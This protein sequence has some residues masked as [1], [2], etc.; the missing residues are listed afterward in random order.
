VFGGYQVQSAHPQMKLTMGDKQTVIDA[1]ITRYPHVESCVPRHCF[2]GCVTGALHYAKQTSIDAEGWFSNCKG[3][4]DIL[5]GRGFT[6]DVLLRGV[7]NYGKWNPLGKLESR[8]NEAISDICGRNESPATRNAA[9]VPITAA[10]DL[11]QRNAQHVSRSPIRKVQVIENPGMLCYF[12]AAIGM[13]RA[14]ASNGLQSAIDA[15]AGP[16]LSM[17]NGCSKEEMRKWALQHKLHVDQPGR[18]DEAFS[19]LIQ[20]HRPL[21]ASFKALQSVHM[22]CDSCCAVSTKDDPLLIHLT[23]KV[24]SNSKVV[25]FSLQSLFDRKTNDVT[26]ADF[27]C[28]TCGKK[29]GATE[30]TRMTQLPDAVFVLVERSYMDRRDDIKKFRLHLKEIES[31]SLPMV[32]QRA[33]ANYRLVATAAY[34]GRPSLGHYTYYSL[35]GTTWFHVNPGA[36]STPGSSRQVAAK[37][38][39]FAQSNTMAV[40]YLKESSRLQ[41]SAMGGVGRRTRSLSLPSSVRHPQGMKR[42]SLAVSASTRRPGSTSPATTMAK[43]LV[44][45]AP[46]TGGRAGANALYGRW[47]RH[48]DTSTSAA[49]RARPRCRQRQRAERSLLAYNVLEEGRLEDTLHDT[50]PW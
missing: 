41:P 10:N 28:P 34:E 38:P 2:Q 6:R 21:Q 33:V 30:T 29:K 47:L 16:L 5:H 11:A 43:P 23:K 46:S 20:L 37:E 24:T 17:A 8:L 26:V 39:M 22:K 48:R 12:S 42:A 32:Q 18:I 1:Q 14:A 27:V 25:D 7:R 13:I 36:Y 15:F 35:L 4:F 19:F 40:L 50:G 45:H 31:V 44:R 49:R 3:I 9:V